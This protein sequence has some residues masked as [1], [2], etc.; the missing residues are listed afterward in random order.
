MSRYR[1]V[2]LRKWEKDLEPRWRSVSAAIKRMDSEEDDVM[3]SRCARISDGGVLDR[4][5]WSRAE[6]SECIGLSVLH[7]H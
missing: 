7:Q 5:I 6:A 2:A 4:Y 3:D 1:S